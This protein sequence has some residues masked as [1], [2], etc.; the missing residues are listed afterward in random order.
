M[1]NKLVK[2]PIIVVVILMAVIYLVRM[3]TNGPW[4]DELYTYYYFISRGP[5][6]AA[7]HWP[8]PNNHVGYSVLSAFL[9]YLGN[10]YIGLRGVSFLAA[11]ANLLLLYRFCARFLDR[12]LSAA[13]T[14]MYCSAYL[15]HSLAVQGRGYTL[16][17]TYL[18][19][20]MTCALNIGMGE[21]RKR[22][23]VL[24]GLSLML[25]LYTIPSSLYWVL[26]ICLT[27]GLF[28]LFAGKK[29]ELFKLFMSGVVAAIGT[30]F[31][32]LLIWLA[33]GANLLSKD[34]SSAF[35]GMNQAKVVLKAPIDSALT[36]IKYMTA[37]PYI[38]SID[39]VQCITGL[40]QYFKELFDNYYDR[41]G[42]VVLVI[43]VLVL[44][45]NLVIAISKRNDKDE[46]FYGAL[47][48]SVFMIFVPVMLVVQSVHP[49]KRV[50]SFLA[51]PL[52]LGLGIICREL[53]DR[54][55]DKKKESAA[56]ICIMAAATLFW[57]LAMTNPYYRAP[58]AD[59]ENELK[60][61]FD[62]INV[63][64]ID[65]IYY[66]DDYQKYVLKF[67]YDVTPTEYYTLEEANYVVIG[68]E[69]RDETYDSPVWPVFY[70]YSEGLI[71]DVSK[72]M[73]VIGGTDNYTIY[74][75]NTD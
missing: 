21:G 20:A 55:K 46:E 2:L 42:S 41:L 37:T 7:I 28:L 68:P 62:T 59:R 12:F 22:D 60:A 11:V 25:G 63:S 75:S 23:Y 38:Q 56:S 61:A 58:M 39:R 45:L 17:I 72:K 69:Q 19:I 51:V 74:A 49:Y 16:V 65:T 24:F 14:L 50:L 34:Q 44:V 5:A 6:Y 43:A 33:I 3:F 8:V 73:V 66:T 29:S 64:D 31:L 71:N 26:P 27:G 57:V 53:T 9:D 67:Y 35:F 1:K 15:I 4:Y 32:Y 10:P 36:G 48:V 30:F 54:I 47:F 18:L 52:T 13:V 40:P 70:P